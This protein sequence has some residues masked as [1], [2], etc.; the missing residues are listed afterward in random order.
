MNRKFFIFQVIMLFVFFLM[1]VTSLN[2][3]IISMSVAFGEY[4]KWITAIQ[5]IP[6][7]PESSRGNMMILMPILILFVFLACW[8]EERMP[9]V[10][11]TIDESIPFDSH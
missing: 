9:S 3:E 8:I 11:T 7:I 4:F 1:F 6:P 5:N 2:P 10:R